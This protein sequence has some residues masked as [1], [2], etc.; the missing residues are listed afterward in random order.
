MQLAKSVVPAKN[1]QNQGHSFG[2]KEF[3]T[4]ART[5][6]YN[7]RNFLN[8]LRIRLNLPKLANRTFF[9]VC[10]C[11]SR[12]FRS[13]IETD[14]LIK[15]LSVI[16]FKFLFFMNSVI[17][18]TFYLLRKGKVLFFCTGFYWSGIFP[19]FTSKFN[20]LPKLF[21]I[22]KCRI[23]LYNFSINLL[24]C[25]YLYLIWN[26]S[27]E[28]CGLFRKYSVTPRRQKCVFSLL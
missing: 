15:Y 18:N 11:W 24:T 14:F 17:K 13:Q 3:K 26:Y 12:L 9:S 27:R 23:T 1:Q 20:A 22:A 25:F 5:V 28:R 16:L 21:G 6:N 10:H 19:I 8:Y 2:S 7:K 4:Q